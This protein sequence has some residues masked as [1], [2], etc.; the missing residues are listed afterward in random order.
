MS[1][2]DEDFSFV[3][4]LEHVTSGVELDGEYLDSEPL[5]PSWLAATSAGNGWEL[6][7]EAQSEPSFPHAD[8]SVVFGNVDN[9]VRAAFQ[10]LPLD[11]PKQV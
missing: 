4:L 9:H 11:A 1:F 3:G 5:E 2:V 10:S 8:E 7:E 6:I